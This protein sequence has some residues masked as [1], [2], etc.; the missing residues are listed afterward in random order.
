MD[1]RLSSTIGSPISGR[2]GDIPH[3]WR[4]GESVC[5]AAGK[6]NERRDR[7]AETRNI[8]L[9]ISAASYEHCYERPVLALACRKRIVTKP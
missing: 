9:K 6:D 2:E 1:G 5:G 4:T 3:S 8:N 7:R